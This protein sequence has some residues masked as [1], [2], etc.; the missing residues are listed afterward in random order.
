MISTSFK[1]D[2]DIGSVWIGVPIPTITSCPP[3]L[4]AFLDVSE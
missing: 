2:A 3:G 1:C 4:V